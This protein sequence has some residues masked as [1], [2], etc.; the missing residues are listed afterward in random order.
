ME[1]RSLLVGLAASV[2]VALTSWPARALAATPKTAEG[3]RLVKILDEI[4]EGFIDLS[5]EM[6]TSLGLDTGKRKD[7]RSRLSDLSEAGVKTTHAFYAKSL[8]A[9]KSIDT[10]KLNPDELPDY[11]SFVGPWTEIIAA[12]NRF[13]YGT[14]GWPEPYVVSQ[15]SGCYRSLP[16]FLVTQHPIANAADAEAYLARC[17]D[18]A[19]QLDHETAR[20]KAAHANGVIAP[21]FIITRTLGMLAAVTSPAPAENRLTTNLAAKTK[22]IAG[23]WSARCTKIIAD[24]IYPALQRQ[25]A[26]VQS[27]AAKATQDAGV[28][29]LPDG[30][31]YYLYALRYA[32][33]TNL[34][35]EEIHQMGLQQMAELTARADGILKAQGYT[36][37]SV[38]DRLTALSKEE[39]FLYPNTEEGKAKL[40]SDL[41]KQIIEVSKKL[42]LAFGRLPKSTVEVRRIPADIESGAPGGYY[43]MPSLDGSRPGAYY[44]NLRDT[45]ENPS[46]SLPTLTY[47]EALPGHHHQIALSLE[48]EGTPALRRMPMYSVFSEGWGLY[49]ERLADELGMYADDPFGELGY[50]QSFMF[51]AAR[52]VVDTGLHHYFWSREQAI[53]YMVESLGM[54]ESA[55]TTEVERYC[56]WP[57]QATSYMVGQLRWYGIREEARAA[58][59]DKFDLRAFHDT[60]LSAGTVPIDVLEKIIRR[61]VAAQKA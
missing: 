36:D 4:Y 42:P 3:I 20:L 26:E 9:L 58:L 50:L 56:I 23:D 31:A 38:A 28:W 12:Q 45:A 30:K 59:G 46:F 21:A 24:K 16:D 57:G 29:S 48:A 34:T 53:Q 54:S 55:V 49:A 44:I 14:G 17:E 5:P 47:H 41:N 11:E 37:G 51:R 25:A 8:A 52:L 2:G 15:L 35:A 39:R 10:S 18:F 7:A 61:W 43:D 6:A 60:A 19:R 33:T 32:T 13:S 1:R 27:V 40:L 22:S